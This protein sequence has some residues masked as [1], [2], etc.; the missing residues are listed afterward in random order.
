MERYI[1]LLRGI[2]VGGNRPVPMPALK[3]LFEENGL[4]NVSTYIQSGNV[5]FSSE[6]NSA[7]AI[8]EKCAD[9]IEARFGFRVPVGVVPARELAETLDHAPVWWNADT[10]AKHNAIFVIPP[11]TPEAVFSEVG[12]TKPEYEQADVYGH[13]IF[14][15]APMKTFSRTRLSR[16]V[17]SGVYDNITIRNAN[18]TLKLR[19]L[20]RA[21]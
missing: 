9:M 15:S 12:G 17:G 11:V 1:A 5:I 6:P 16:V 8:R 13:V 19:E 10:D 18:T 14:W 3:A 7:D 2:N 20:T 4:E 21:D